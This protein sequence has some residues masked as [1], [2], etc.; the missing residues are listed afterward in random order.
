MT[1]RNGNN[2]FSGGLI[3]DI[4][5][6]VEIFNLFGFKNQASFQWVKTVNNQEGIPNIFA[7]PNYLTG[8]LLNLRLMVKF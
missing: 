3:E 4:S 2:R 6:S 7:V 5:F 1:D 8:R